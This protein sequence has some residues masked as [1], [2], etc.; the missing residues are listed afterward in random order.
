MKK[1][2]NKI[3]YRERKANEFHLHFNNPLA[4]NFLENSRKRK[5]QKP[6]GLPGLS[7]RTELRRAED[8]MKVCSVFMVGVFMVIKGL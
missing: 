6:S 5:L 8:T 3:A 1:I 2:R 4:Q 7:E